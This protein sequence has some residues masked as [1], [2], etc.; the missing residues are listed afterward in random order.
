[1]SGLKQVGRPIRKKDAMQLVTGQ[2]VYT[3]DIAPRDCLVIRLKRS[4]HANARILSID[5]TAAL[6][7]PGV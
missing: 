3:E 4:P 5:K 1:M 6:K 7:V 2:G